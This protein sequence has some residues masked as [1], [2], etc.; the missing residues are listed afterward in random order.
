[1]MDDIE[2]DAHKDILKFTMLSAIEKIVAMDECISEGCVPVVP[3][4]IVQSLE[5]TLPLPMAELTRHG[6]REQLLSHLANYGTL[7]ELAPKWIWAEAYLDSDRRIFFHDLLH[8]LDAEDWQTSHPDFH[9]LFMS[10]APEIEA[11]IDTAFE[12]PW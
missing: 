9:S 11:R 10:I 12:I 7:R 1:M 5:R 8:T 3:E 6:L 2:I 4:E